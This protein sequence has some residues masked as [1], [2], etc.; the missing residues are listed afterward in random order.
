MQK[1]PDASDRNRGDACAKKRDRPNKRK[2]LTFFSSE[3]QSDN[4][5]L[6]GG[7]RHVFVFGW[8]VG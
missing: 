2:N 7:G 6:T 8:R 5:L 4:T 3:Q 1:F